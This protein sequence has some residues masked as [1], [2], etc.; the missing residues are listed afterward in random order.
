MGTELLGDPEVAE[1]CRRC[2][3]AANVDLRRLL[4]EAG[5]EELKLTQNA[6]PALLFAGVGLALLLRRRG[7][8]PA[9][10]AGHSVGEYTALC[11][12]GALSPED[13]VKVVVPRGVAMADAAPAGTPPK[14]AVLG[15]GPQAVEGAPLRVPHGRA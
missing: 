14:I 4:T 2:S 15:P 6:Q 1:L 7:I 12:A 8:E 13:A 11:V 5:E 9:A 10:A 3:D